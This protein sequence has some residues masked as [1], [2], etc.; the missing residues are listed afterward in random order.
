MSKAI[1]LK[2]DNKINHYAITDKT[3]VDEDELDKKA[4]L[5]NAGYYIYDST[6]D[7]LEFV[8]KKM[9]ALKPEAKKVLIEYLENEKLAN[10]RL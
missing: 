3:T 5:I 6:Y 7:F 4:S 8:Q 1:R 9:C 2:F 10:T